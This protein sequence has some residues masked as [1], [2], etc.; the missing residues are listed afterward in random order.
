MTK[1]FL[2]FV[3]FFKYFITISQDVRIGIFPDVKFKNLNVTVIN[4]EYH[5]FPDTFE[6]YKVYK[7][8][9]INTL[10]N[11]S[12][13]TLITN[14]DT[15]FRGI[16]NLYL[17]S[18]ES[19]SKL[20]F[21][22]SNSNIKDCSFYGNFLFR[23]DSDFIQIINEIDIEKYVAG[24]VE[25]EA[26]FKAEPEFYKA[27]AIIARTYCIANLYRHASEGYH[28][29]NRPHCQVYFGNQEKNIS[30]YD[31]V[32]ETKGLILTDVN[33]MP[34]NAVYHANCGGMTCDASFV[35]QK[36]EPYLK[37]V[38]DPFCTDFKWTAKI[39]IKQWREFLK[40]NNIKYKDTK[41]NF[42]QEERLKNLNY[43][44]TQIQLKKIREAFNLK[45]SYFSINQ[46]GNYLIF[47]GRGHGHGV[48]L[49]QH[50]A[51]E[52]A[53]VGYTYV[54]ILHF[55]FQNVNIQNLNIV[56]ALASKTW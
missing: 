19:D 56:Q 52:M 39:S 51:M 38:K 2:I 26:G 16:K 35:W 14:N 12:L 4:G 32:F 36:S 44:N 21:S 3:F 6:I 46:H 54:D 11:D 48:G 5:I 30:I 13:I 7:N 37:S 15:I 55:Y 20:K 28:L 34:I 8:D 40:E 18:N 45:S 50:G 9:I 53:R 25:A 22:F 43:N 23:A 33:D 31:A 41:I 47:K 42:I 1:L 17:K 27:Q 29:C 24:V 49:C 10:I